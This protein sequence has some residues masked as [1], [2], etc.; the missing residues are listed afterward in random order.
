MVTAPFSYRPWLSVLLLVCLLMPFSIAKAALTASVDRTVISKDD[1]IQLTIRSTTGPLDQPDFSEVQKN[2]NILSQQR[3]NQY[4]NINGKGQASY[5]LILSLSPRDV[6]T[7]I[8]PAFESRGETSQALQIEVSATSVNTQQSQKE[9]FFDNEINKQEVYAQEQLLFTLRL[10]HSVGLSG[11]EITPLKV[12]NAVIEPVG[13]QKK[14]RVV[15]DGIGYSVVERQYAIFPEKSGELI[16]PELVFSGRAISNPYGY[17]SRTNR[18]NVLSAYDYIHT[19]STGYTIKVLPKPANYPASKPWLPTSALDIKDSWNNSLPTFTVG[20]PVTRTL[21]LSAENLSAT[22]LPKLEIQA[23]PHLKMYPDQPQ[24]KNS[25]TANGLLGQRSFSIAIVPTVAGKVEVPAIDVTWW[26]TITK[27]VEVSSVPAKTLTVLPAAGSSNTA[28]PS[29]TPLNAA[30]TPIQNITPASIIKTSSTLWP[31]LSL[32][33]ALLWLGTMFVWWRSRQSVGADVKPNNDF[34]LSPS[35]QNT[36]SAYRR[37]KKACLKNDAKDTRPA[38]INWFRLSHTQQHTQ[39]LKDI[40]QFYQDDVLTNLIQ[41]LET[42]LY[43]NS[44]AVD[45]WQGKALFEAI[46]RLEKN[47]RQQTGAGSHDRLKPL[48]PL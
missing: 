12:D 46:E 35:Q 26:N 32:V 14:Y 34:E 33:F 10:Y 28:Q 20:K 3:N 30:A 22:Q 37:F 24:D 29:S 7:F 8:I 45:S 17:N 2:F 43:G 27:Q 18:S 39:Q 9:V 44:Q 16:L 19:R 42:L 21:T 25:T 38:L 6:G 48:Y 11:A 13:D 31:W 47:N 4:S 23:T 40:T 15:I 36:R 1:I 41:A 5:S